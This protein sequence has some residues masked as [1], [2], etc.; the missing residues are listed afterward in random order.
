MTMDEAMVVAGAHLAAEALA[1]VLAR[2]NAALAKMD[3]RAAGALGPAKAVA[4]AGFIAAAK[5]SR[6]L[7]R[8][9]GTRLDTLA[10]ANRMLLERAMAAQQ[11]VVA[12]VVET[13]RQTQDA[14]RYTAKGT[15]AAE[16]RAM[17]ISTRI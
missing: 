2:E 15:P 14:A 17:A 9:Q 16:R 11:A 8:E 1:E 5:G 6:R 4:V 13:A 10:Q 12:A 3:F 7:E